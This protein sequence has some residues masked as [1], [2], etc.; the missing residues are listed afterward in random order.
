MEIKPTAEKL[1]C[2]TPF[3][4]QLFAVHLLVHPSMADSI[5]L[6]RNLVE[7]NCYLIFTE[8]LTDH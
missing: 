1:H 6:E 4:E 5:K 8:P 2:R 7:R 3:V